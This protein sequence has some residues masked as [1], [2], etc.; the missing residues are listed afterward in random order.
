[1]TLSAKDVYDK[2]HEKSSRLHNITATFLINLEVPTAKLINE[3]KERIQTIKESKNIQEKNTKYNKWDTWAM[4]L[5]CFDLKKGGVKRD[6]IIKKY[7][8]YCYDGSQIND[9]WNLTTNDENRW[10]DAYNPVCKMIN[11]D[12][13]SLAGNP[14]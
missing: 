9:D 2:Y 10:N 4:G 14:E 6:V 13:K 1:M 3:L 7:L 11:G 12:W 8:S 5:A